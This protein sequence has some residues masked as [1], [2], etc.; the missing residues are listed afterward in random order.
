MDDDSPLTYS[1]LVWS[2]CAR[3]ELEILGGCQQVGP[4]LENFGELRAVLVRDV[5]LPTGSYRAGAPTNTDFLS[6]DRDAIARA[7][8]VATP[9][10]PFRCS[11]LNTC[12]VVVT[13]ALLT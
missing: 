13:S 1:G 8:R 9:L 6:D 5:P 12:P 7:P 10:L 4:G 2:I 11:A 3:A